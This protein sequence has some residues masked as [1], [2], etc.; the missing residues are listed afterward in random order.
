MKKKK[1]ELRKMVIY[2]LFVEEAK[3]LAVSRQELEQEAFNDAKSYCAIRRKEISKKMLYD[4]KL[5]TLQIN[6]T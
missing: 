2:A 3:K 1:I 4:K 5:A 6:N